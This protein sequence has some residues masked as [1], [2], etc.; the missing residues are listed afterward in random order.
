MEINI[1]QMM[2][3]TGVK[4]GTSGVRGLVSAMDNT[5]VIAYTLAFVKALEIQPGAEVAI[6]IDLRPS[7]P[8]IAQTCFSAL[9]SVGINARYFGAIP[10]PALAYYAEQNNMPSIMVTGSHIPYD[11]NGIKFYSAAG[12]ITK[13]HELDIACA[14]VEFD[15]NLAILSLPEVD[16]E[17]KRFYVKRYV[18]FFDRSFFTDKTIAFYQ[19]SS[20]G[21]DVLTEILEALGASVLPLGRTN[22]FVPIDTEA[23][24]QDDIE[25]A[26][27]WADEYN[28]DSIISTD[29]DADRPLIGDENGDWLRGDI[30][31]LLTAQFLDIQALAIPVSCNTAIEKCNS[32]KKVNRTK[33]GSPYVIESLN[34]L[35]K[36][37]YNGVAGFEA[38]GGFMLASDLSIA[39]KSLAALCTR[40]AV[41]PILA[42]IA[43]SAKRSLPVSSLANDLPP[44]FT[45][46]DRIKNFATEKSQQLI[47]Q[48]T[49]KP[50]KI[51]VLFSECKLN[52]ASIDITDGLRITM[53]NEEVIHYRPSGNAPELRCY[54]ESDSAKRSVELVK[55]ALSLIQ[56]VSV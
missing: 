19:H 18:E 36:G 16:L 52:Y 4:F 5:L 34:F 50:S 35:L 37:S 33:I 17:A 41:L 49:E 10:T 11:R 45:A 9:K 7:S 13:Q 25:Q 42:I 20:V 26:K 54:A 55:S 56:T 31:G 38:N 14:T 28:F 29:G 2:D 12:E 53:T 47:T 44:R 22:D 23:V 1:Q 51:D 3:Q 30:V 15:S 43:L 21:R 40:D 46:S 24:A 39:N 6:A 27:K 48:F 8:E 32:F